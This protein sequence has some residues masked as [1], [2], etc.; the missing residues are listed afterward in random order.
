MK[1]CSRCGFEADENFCPNCGTRG[2]DNREGR[3]TDCTWN[4]GTQPSVYGI[5]GIRRKQCAG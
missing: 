4:G 3:S 1:K 2:S 5:T